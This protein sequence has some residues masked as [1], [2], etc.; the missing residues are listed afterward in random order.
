MTDKPHCLTC[1]DKMCVWR[2]LKDVRYATEA[3]GCLSHPKAKEYLMKE[4]CENC[5]RPD[6]DTCNEC[7]NQ[8]FDGG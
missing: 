4:A 2:D 3:V 8:N 6:N 7:A 5:S 1:T